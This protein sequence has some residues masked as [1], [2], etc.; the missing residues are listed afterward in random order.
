MENGVPLRIISS[1]FV[2]GKDI[3]LG[4]NSSRDNLTAKIFGPS[5]T[6]ISLANLQSQPQTVLW[7]KVVS[8]G[9]QGCVVQ[10]P[11]QIQPGAYAVLFSHSVNSPDNKA[12][13]FLL[14]I[15]DPSAVRIQLIFSFATCLVNQELHWLADCSS[16]GPGLLA[17]T[18]NGDYVTVEQ[19]LNGRHIIHFTPRSVG[20]YILEV[21]YNGYHTGN[22]LSFHVQ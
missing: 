7:P 13:P 15:F 6:S 9:S 3:F 2:V 21:T 18:V 4:L 20:L 17:C 8:K 19:F 5:N 12:E 16:A 22:T 14:N 1:Y 11:A 10:L